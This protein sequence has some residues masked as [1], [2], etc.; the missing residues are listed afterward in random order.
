MAAVF[1]LYFLDRFMEVAGPRVVPQAL[2]LP[3]NFILGSRRQGGNG[4]EMVHPAVIIGTDGFDFRLLQHDFRHPDLIR[5]PRR[6]IAPGQITAMGGKP[7]EEQ[8]APM[9]FL[10]IHINKPLSFYTINY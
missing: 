1:G 9:F 10:Y 8:R 5:I 7:V 3:Q 2:P 4:R 6:F